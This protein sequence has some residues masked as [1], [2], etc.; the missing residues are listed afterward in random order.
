[1]QDRSAD[2]PQGIRGSLS[3][4]CKGVLQGQSGESPGHSSLVM[5]YLKQVQL[6]QSRQKNSA[7]A[8]LELETGPD[9]GAQGRTC[10]P[11]DPPLDKPLNWHY[12]LGRV[13]QAS[14]F[15][16]TFFFFWRV[17]QPAIPR[18][19]YPL[20]MF[21]GNKNFDC[22][23][24]SPRPS[25]SGTTLQASPCRPWDPRVTGSYHLCCGSASSLTSSLRRS[26]WSEERSKG[27]PSQ[28]RYPE[29]QACPAV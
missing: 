15:V 16:A 2:R 24:A 13:V 1:L 10:S 18:K 4:R 5:L 19:H 26:L 17:V 29:V 8:R 3:W 21:L 20:H 14:R 9:G 28:K 7:S 25:Q 27:K 12:R 22:C 6:L 11:R 23:R